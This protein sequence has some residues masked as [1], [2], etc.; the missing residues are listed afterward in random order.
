MLQ[1]NT[2]AIT[3]TPVLN[4]NGGILT[5]NTNIN[6]GTG[7][8]TGS[9]INLKSGTNQ[10][11]IYEY[12]DGNCF[13]DNNAL[14]S[15]IF[16]IYPSGGNAYGVLQLSQSGVNI[17]GISTL[18]TTSSTIPLNVTGLITANGGLT[19]PSGQ[20]LTVNGTFSPSTVSPSGLIT[21]NGGIT[22]ANNQYIQMST[23][24]TTAPSSTGQIG[25]IYMGGS[26][27][28]VTI[29]NSTNTILTTYTIPY[30]GVYMFQYIFSVSNSSA[31]PTNITSG[32]IYIL[33][34]S[35]CIIQNQIIPQT[36]L[37]GGYIYL[38]GSGF[39]STLR[40]GYNNV[41]KITITMNSSS[42]P[43]PQLTCVGTTFDFMR[44]A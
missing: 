18:G 25:Y 42:V 2:S 41:M 12:S 13:Y 43:A 16:R 20:T 17:G 26:L 29:S 40:T 4:A 37:S 8:I 36:I 30:N 5:N 33:S 22:M 39:V 27:S 9:T 32:Y 3:I 1:M 35:Q 24:N 31:L 28:T 10:L 14:Q 15:H 21:A 19:I 7:S 44:I 23:S 38:S 11:Q 34:N 6:T